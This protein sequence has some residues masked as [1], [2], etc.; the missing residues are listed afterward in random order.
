MNKRRLIKAYEIAEELEKQ[1]CDKYTLVDWDGSCCFNDGE[2]VRE[3]CP[4][5][6]GYP[7][8]AHTFRQALEE[9]IS[10]SNGGK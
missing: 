8:A 9:I 3:Y 5:S 10:K 7:C 6:I 2:H 4:F 1:C